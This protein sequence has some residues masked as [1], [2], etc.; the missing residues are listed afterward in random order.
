MGQIKV[1]GRQGHQ[2]QCFDAKSGLPV[3]AGDVLQGT[4]KDDGVAKDPAQEISDAYNPV[5]LLSEMNKELEG[6]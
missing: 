1:N 5:N 4:D 6:Q 3:D 2:G